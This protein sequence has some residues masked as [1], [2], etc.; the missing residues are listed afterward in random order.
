[1]KSQMREA[2]R[3]GVDFVFIIGSDELETGQVTVRRMNNGEQTSV[4]KEEIISW[5]EAG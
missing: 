5:M 3:H 1:M 2:N 4:K